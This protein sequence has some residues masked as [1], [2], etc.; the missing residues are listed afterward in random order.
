[1]FAGEMFHSG[2]TYEIWLGMTSKMM[3]G[4][5]DSFPGAAAT[6]PPDQYYIYV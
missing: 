4:V 2:L 3:L 5:A 6:L 1:M